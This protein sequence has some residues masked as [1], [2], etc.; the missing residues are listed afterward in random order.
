MPRETGGTT[1]TELAPPVGLPSAPAVPTGAAVATTE[2]NAPRIAV[3]PPVVPSAPPAAPAAVTPEPAAASPVPSAPDAHAVDRQEIAAL[4]AE[5]AAA[6]R[7]K[8]A[9][10]IASLF[11]AAPVR[12]LR[13]VFDFATQVEFDL[14]P[15]GAVQF[16]EGGNSAAQVSCRRTTRIEYRDRRNP[17]VVNDTV[18]VKLSRIRGVWRI[19]SIQ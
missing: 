8:D 3:P 19:Q 12:D 9:T 13:A 15:V 10:R 1:T 11:P 14:A 5:Y 18:T 16:A 17:Q 2:G 4:L 7:R 6:W